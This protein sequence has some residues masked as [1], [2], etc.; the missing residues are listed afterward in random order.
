MG[1]AQG[2]IT[3]RRRPKDGAAGD[4]AMRLDLNNENDSLLYDAEGNL[5]SG[6]VVTVATLYKGEAAVSSGVVG[7]SRNY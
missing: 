4:D 1:Q 5:L 2:H 7:K 3:V 6:S